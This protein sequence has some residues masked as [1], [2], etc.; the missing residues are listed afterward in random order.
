[1]AECQ[2]LLGV[3]NL[4]N[5]DEEVASFL[6]RV[7]TMTTTA[8]VLVS[9]KKTSRHEILVAVNL[10]REAVPKGRE[11]ESH[12]RRLLL[13]RERRIPVLA[14]MWKAIRPIVPN[15]SPD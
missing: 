1:M 4:V 14:I 5:N 8:Q 10:E 7:S 6:D 12:P 15:P 11:C 9:G 13:T 2:L 3:L